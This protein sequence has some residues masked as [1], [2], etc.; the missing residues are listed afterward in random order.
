M[1]KTHPASRAFLSLA[2]FWH[3]Q[4]KTLYKLCNKFFDEHVLHVLLF[5]PRF[6]RRALG[7]SGKI[8]LIMENKIVFYK[9]LAQPF[10]VSFGWTSNTTL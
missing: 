8:S 7:I 3:S 9:L 2:P 6:T 10:L 5:N 1:R 4:E